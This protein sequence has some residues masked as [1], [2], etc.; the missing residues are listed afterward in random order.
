MLFNWRLKKWKQLATVFCPKLFWVSPLRILCLHI[1]LRFSAPSN[2]FYVQ[3]VQ[4]IYFASLAWKHLSNCRNS[5]LKLCL[6]ENYLFSISC[7]LQPSFPKK[8]NRFFLSFFC[9]KKLGHK[10]EILV[11]KCNV[12][13]K[14]L[15]HVLHIHISI[16][17]Q[18]FQFCHSVSS[19]LLFLAV[20]QFI[21]LLSWSP[22]SAL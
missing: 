19:L 2:L 10:I 9:R 22:S 6:Q 4:T 18:E 14:P 7:C 3:F 20:T 1:S 12:G 17:R 16:L 11:S 5:S 21:V 15:L 8:Y 13:F